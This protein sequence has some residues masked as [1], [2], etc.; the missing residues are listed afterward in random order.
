MSAT[1]LA[2]GM[3][4]PHMQIFRQNHMVTCANYFPLQNSGKIV[5][6]SITPVS[7]E[8][9]SLKSASVTFEKEA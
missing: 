6:L 3:Y 9:D 5:N 7:S 4:T 2:S 1:S 8:S